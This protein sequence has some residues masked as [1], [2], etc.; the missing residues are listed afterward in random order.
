MQKT[1]RIKLPKG[2]CV[3]VSLGIDLDAQTIWEGAYGMTSP[4]ALAYGEFGAEVGTPR[5]L[6]LFDKYNIKT[7]WFIPGKTADTFPDACKEV[8]ARGHEIAHHSYYHRNPANMTYQEEEAVYKK[9]LDSL[10]RIGANNI[11]GYRSAYWDF[12]P[13]TLKII[14]KLGI[15]YDSSLMANDFYPYYPRTMEVREDGGNIFK[16]TSNIVEFPPSWWLTDFPFIAHTPGKLENMRP[17]EELYN[18]YVSNYDY[19]VNKCP[20]SCW[21]LTSHPQT[22]GRAHEIQMYEDVIR[23]LESHGAW[24]ATM[25]EMYDACYSEDD[26]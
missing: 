24:F 11:R 26:K 15:K 9:A 12:S 14:E 17:T 25:G 6:D 5:L 4:A 18:R 8:I 16:E 21:C 23:Y 3:A 1:L 10:A 20:N 7:T 19:A 22:M 2:K 13:N